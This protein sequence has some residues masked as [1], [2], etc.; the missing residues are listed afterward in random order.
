MDLQLSYRSYVHCQKSRTAKT[1]FYFPLLM[2]FIFFL[3]VGCE[4]L[5]FKDPLSGPF[6]YKFEIEQ[7]VAKESRFYDLNND[8]QEEMIFIK[9]DSYKKSGNSYAH[10]YDSHFTLINQLNFTGEIRKYF[11]I[12]WTEDGN[13]EIFFAFD[14]NDSLFLR[15]IDFRGKTLV[16]K[17]FLLSG[18][19]RISSSGEKYDWKGKVDFLFY[20]DL[21]SDGK[22]ELILFPDEAYACKPRGVYV[23]D[24]K[25]FKLKWKYEIGA[26]IGET[27]IF[28]D[29]N[30][31]GLL[32]IVIPTTAPANGHKMNGTDDYHS[33]LLS[34]DCTGELKWQ[35]NFGGKFT[36][37]STELIDIDGDGK[38]E[39]LSFF[40]N[41]NNSNKKPSIHIINPQN[42][43]SLRSR[44]FNMSKA[45][46][47]FIQADRKGSKELIVCDIGSGSAN[48]GEDHG[49]DDENADNTHDDLLGSLL[50]FSV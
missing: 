32:E 39:I 2:F 18:K 27:P 8:G 37:V 16:N 30:K 14:N 6:P 12:D 1:I 46:Y 28:I 43:Q 25:S 41:W 34:F 31:D 49:Q 21:D 47:I 24:G 50:T 38:D 23:Y 4:S 7:P 13:N 9:N 5:P 19:N 40:S 48:H 17:V 26:S 10:I 3:I 44:E 36:S 22:K 15:I 11:I 42:G 35:R 29:S 33:Y 20:K 45:G